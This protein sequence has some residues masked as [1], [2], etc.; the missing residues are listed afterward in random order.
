MSGTSVDGIDAAAIGVDPDVCSVLASHQHPY[1]ATLRDALQHG[2]EAQAFTLAEAARLDAMVGEEF[3]LACLELMSDL[4]PTL[5]N[6]IAAIGSHGQTILHSPRT[7]PRYTVQI[8]DPNIIA[9]RTR[10]CVVAD[11]RRRDL[12]HEGE[13]APL[14]PLFHQA[15]FGNATPRA[16]IN[17]GGIANI[18]I[19]A[20][21]PG[22]EA[23]TLGFDTGPSNALMDTWTERHH[24]QAYDADGAWARTGRPCQELL[25]QLLA[26]PYF[27]LEPPK[28]TGREL[29]NLSWL[30]R[31]GTTLLESLSPTDVQRTLLEL[32]VT[33]VAK[34]VND[35]LGVDGE[36]YLCGGGSRNGFVR[37]RLAEELQGRPVQTTAALGIDPQWVECA[38]FAWLAHRRLNGL[39][40]NASSVTGARERAVLGGV[41]HG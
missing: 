2:I 31:R 5:R 8:G 11:F 14:A 26:D 27:D 15:A 39:P 12:A 20:T 23:P 37:E 38:T 33:S 24:E 25:A 1:P 19:L 13:G 16:V 6:Q 35:N 34:G 7:T 21:Q 30:S 41:Y 17:L 4:E 29:F 28:T 9:A 32:T 18:S 36:V 22:A 3:A 40:G 10:L